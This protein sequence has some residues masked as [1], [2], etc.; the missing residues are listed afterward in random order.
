MLGLD[1]S[2]RLPY[3]ADSLANLEESKTDK[4]YNQWKKDIV[5]FANSLVRTFA[6]LG[7][8]DH[9]IIAEVDLSYLKPILMALFLGNTQEKDEA[10]KILSELQVHVKGDQ[11]KREANLV[12]WLLKRKESA[13][14]AFP[15]LKRVEDI[16]TMKLS[17]RK[18]ILGA[19]PESVK[20]I[21]KIVA[22]AI[23][24]ATLATV[25]FGLIQVFLT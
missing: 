10:K 9:R 16:L 22:I 8:F 2:K 11:R 14:K 17:I 5:Y 7:P 12:D 4:E 21:D 18:G 23:G 6:K 25:I 24:L 19:T 15:R 3:I 1:A 13:P 20:Y